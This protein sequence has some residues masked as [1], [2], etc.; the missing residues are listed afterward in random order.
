M[1]F[2]PNP[3]HEAIRDSVRA[4]I[5]EFPDAYWLGKEERH[6]YP[7]EFYDGFAK[8]GFLGIAIPEIYGGSGLGITEA[9]LGLYEVC[10]SGA[11]LNGASAV[12]LSMF[13][14]NPVVK[15][16]SEE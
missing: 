5:T 13:G 12:H 7:H 14:I 9:G 11:G 1:N 4:L 15:H 3:D 8:A 6:E 10:A 16:G 2:A